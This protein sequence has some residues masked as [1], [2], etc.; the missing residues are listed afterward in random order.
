MVYAAANVTVTGGSSEYTLTPNFSPVSGTSANRR[1]YS[2]LRFVRSS[3]TSPVVQLGGKQ[4]ID[5]HNCI[6]DANYG[7][8]QCLNNVCTINDRN[9]TTYHIRFYD[10]TF[11]S[12]IDPSTG[13]SKSK[14]SFECTGRAPLSGS[15]T[16]TYHH[17][18]HYRSVF[19]PGGYEAC[20]FDDVFNKN[21]YGVLNQE[22]Y[23][24]DCVFGGGGNTMVYL[25]G[26]SSLKYGQNFELNGNYG[27]TVI[28]GR[29]QRTRSSIYNLQGP[30]GDCDWY[31]EDCTA[32]FDDIHANHVVIPGSSGTGQ[33]LHANN[34]DRS[35]WTRCTFNSGTNPANWASHNGDM[36]RTTAC[37][38]NTFSSATWAGHEPRLWYV[39]GTGNVGLP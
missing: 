5:F 35:Q 20:S 17:I 32:S 25:Y 22:I 37:N 34:M 2:N 6:F 31:F 38:Y 11:K 27:A 30:A 29:F 7:G 24:E 19:Y 12:Y 18:E 36:G 4:Y 14:M 1:T 8:Y 15:Y 16:S 26:D 10:C 9:G 39:S 28:R 33:T 3:T 21:G 23:L 13:Y